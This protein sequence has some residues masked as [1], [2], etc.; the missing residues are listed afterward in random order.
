[1]PTVGHALPTV[2]ILLGALLL[3]G[4]FTRVM[5]LVS[6]LF[7]VAFIIGISS[8]WARGLEIN[9]GCFGN[10][11]VPANP[12]R[13]YALDIARDIGLLLCAAWLVCWPR[14]RFAL[15]NLLFPRTERLPDGGEEAVEV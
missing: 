13:E 10:A 9:C 15:D 14:T 12:Q 4:L 11:G 2:E 8:A 1:M 3:L 6:V 7:F 5:A